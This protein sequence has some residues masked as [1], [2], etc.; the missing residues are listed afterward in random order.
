VRA[1]SSRG[2]MTTAHELGELAAAAVV[3]ACSPTLVCTK[4]RRG[5]ERER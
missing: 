5:R 1:E 3:V 4:G 2:A